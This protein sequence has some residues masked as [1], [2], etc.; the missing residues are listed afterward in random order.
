[1]LVFRVRKQIRSWMRL[2]L[3]IS[4]CNKLITTVIIDGSSPSLRNFMNMCCL[5]SFGK[6]EIFVSKKIY[7]LTKMNVHFWHYVDFLM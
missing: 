5:N 4:V 6:L 7:P 2:Y 3:P 1:M